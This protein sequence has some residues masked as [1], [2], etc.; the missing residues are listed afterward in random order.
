[1][2]ICM[3]SYFPACEWMHT[4]AVA[5]AIQAAALQLR[6]LISPHLLMLKIILTR[7]NNC[8][9]CLA[10]VQL[11]LHHFASDVLLNAEIM[12]P[13]LFCLLLLLFPSHL[14]LLLLFFF[15]IFFFTFCIKKCLQKVLNL[16][17]FAYSFFLGGDGGLHFVKKKEKKPMR[18]LYF[19]FTLWGFWRTQRALLFYS[20]A[21]YWSTLVNQCS[22]TLKELY[23]WRQLWHD[24]FWEAMQRYRCMVYL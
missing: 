11:W 23:M 4:H 22:F 17:S 16:A 10:P 7:E 20:V 21:K 2:K 5:S 1:M 8:N 3:H 12:K 15:F 6:G 18:Y 9:T 14:F 19:L 24:M 13:W